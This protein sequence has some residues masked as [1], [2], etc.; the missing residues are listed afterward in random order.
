MSEL[1]NTWLSVALLRGVPSDH[2]GDQ[3]SLI[4][5]IVAAAMSSVLVL[6][7]DLELSSAIQ[8]AVLDLVFTGVCLSVALQLTGK[9][10]RFTQAFATYCG[11]GTVMNLVVLLMLNIVPGNAAPGNELTLIDLFYFLQLVWAISIVARILR[12]TFEIS[13]PISVL[14]AT[15]YLLVTITVVG[16]IMS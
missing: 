14:A 15:G 1:L 16:L 12:F 3:K 7:V 11:A 5:A 8:L 4:I 10:P 9:T 2:P 6:A 13:L